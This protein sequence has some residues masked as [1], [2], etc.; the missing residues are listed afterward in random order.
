MDLLKFIS[1]RPR[2]SLL[3]GGLMIITGF[4]I[5]DIPKM[6]ISPEW[7]TTDGKIISRR[8]SGVKFEEYDG[9]YYEKIEAYIRYK[10]CVDDIP[11]TSNVINVTDPLY[12]PYDIAA[13]YPEGKGVTV[14]YNPKIPSE[15]VLEPGFV[16]FFQGIDR[17]T[18]ILF[19]TGKY[20]IHLG[21]SQHKLNKIRK[22]IRRSS[23]CLVENTTSK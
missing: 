6:I 14:Y 2:L 18:Y 9:D 4:F 21:I 22:S 7:P 15:A 10:Y 19:V 11:Y 23:T 20:F 3:I 17:Y 8:L 16:D 1:D 12:Y 13:R 5:T